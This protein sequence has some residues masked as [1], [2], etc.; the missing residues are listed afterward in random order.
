M[1]AVQLA[2]SMFTSSS[3]NHFFIIERVS[4]DHNYSRMINSILL[5]SS[6]EIQC[7]I[8]YSTGTVVV[9]FSIQFY[10]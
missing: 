9:S 3:G 4:S 1:S 7:S 8:E 10:D 5:T 2:V 6:S